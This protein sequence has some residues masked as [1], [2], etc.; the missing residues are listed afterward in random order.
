MALVR[1]GNSLWTTQ[2][3][4]TSKL[5]YLLRYKSYALIAIISD[6]LVIH[7]WQTLQSNC[8]VQLTGSI[9]RHFAL[10]FLEFCSRNRIARLFIYYRRKTQ[11]I[12]IAGFHCLAICV[13]CPG[14]PIKGGLINGRW[15][16]WQKS[17]RKCA[18]R[19]KARICMHLLN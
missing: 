1:A 2:L 4:D 6:Y 11:Y 18:I 17:L 3:Q 12:T 9:L 13:Q 19:K 8:Y 10:L 7:L 14:C 5:F 16:Y 15:R